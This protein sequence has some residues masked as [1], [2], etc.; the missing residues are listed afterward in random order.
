MA[1][2]REIPEQTVLDEFESFR[3][4]HGGTS[5]VYIRKVDDPSCVLLVDRFDE[6][7]QM[8]IATEG[9]P[10]EYTGIVGRAGH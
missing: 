5:Q 10:G 1:G 6:D 4:N 7:R 9:Q 2:T 3:I 8:Y